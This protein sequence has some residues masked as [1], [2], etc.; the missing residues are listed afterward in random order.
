MGAHELGGAPDRWATIR[1][2]S[3]CDQSDTDA[4]GRSAPGSTLPD[5]SLS[6][7]DFERPRTLANVARRTGPE[8][9]GT[10][11]RASG[12]AG[13]AFLRWDKLS[14]PSPRRPPLRCHSS[15]SLM[16]GGLDRP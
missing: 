16:T 14:S 10:L 13:G 7:P 1:K 5:A 8:P 4:D 6:R 11:P 2:I 12:L 15:G 9:N 3:R